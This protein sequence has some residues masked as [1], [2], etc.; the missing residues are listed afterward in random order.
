MQDCDA[1]WAGAV[2][3]ETRLLKVFFSFLAA[4]SS[5]LSVQFVSEVSMVYT[6]NPDETY[7]GSVDLS[8][9]TEE[10]ERQAKAVVRGV[11]TANEVDDVEKIWTNAQD[12]DISIVELCGGITNR[13]YLIGHKNTKVILRTFGNGTEAFIDRRKENLVFAQLSQTG[14]GPAFH[15]LIEGGRIEGYLPSVTLQPQQ[16]KDPA[17]YPKVAGALA[18]L[19]SF[20][21]PPLQTDGWLWEKIRLFFELADKVHFDDAA[22]AA[23]L[24]ALDLPRMRDQLQGLQ[25][26][27]AA[28]RGK[29]LGRSSEEDQ[30]RLFAFEEVLCHNDLLS[31]N[32]LLAQPEA[33]GQQAPKRDVYLIDFEYAAYNHRGFDLANHFCEFGGFDFDV[34]T[35]FPSEELRK[36]FLRHYLLSAGGDRSDAFVQGFHDVSMV[37]CLASHLSWGAWAVVQAGQTTIDFDYLTYAGRRFEGVAH[38]ERVFAALIQ[39]LRD[40]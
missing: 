1:K 35:Q 5:D 22:Q 28:A 17:I 30:G 40:L 27:L 34:V 11:M 3:H 6:N 32:I 9:P 15:G 16:M 4:V 25:D 2:G 24:A 18:E 38:H 8:L 19:H 33:G 26:L 7:P 31:G 23:K 10:V 29:L 36:A 37:L 14:F 13:L 21:C 20:S 39:Q 12:C